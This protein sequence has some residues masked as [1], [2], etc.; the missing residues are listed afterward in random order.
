LIGL[1][2]GGIAPP[3]MFNSTPPPPLPAPIERNPYDGCKSITVKGIDYYN[4]EGRDNPRRDYNP[5]YQDD[6]YPDRADNGYQ[7][8]YQGGYQDDAYPDQASEEA[9]Q[10]RSYQ[11]YGEESD[12]DRFENGEAAYRYAPL[13]RTPL[14]DSNGWEA[15]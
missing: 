4:C 12:Q 5:R 11:R 10:G 1:T 2:F 9:Y 8:G 6:V 14:Y 7:G 15:K 3:V 13:S